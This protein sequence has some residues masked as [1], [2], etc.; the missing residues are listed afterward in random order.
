[1]PASAAP[2]HRSLSLLCAVSAAWAFSFGLGA[3]LASLWLADH[4][5]GPTVIGLNTAAYYAGIAAA[6]APLPWLMTRSARACVVAGLVLAALTTAFFPAVDGL[7][8]W[9]LIRAVNGLS[10]ALFLIPIETLVNRGA[11]PRRR[12]RD[13]GLYASSIALGIGLG[14]VVGLPVY[15]QAPRLAFVLGGLLPLLVTAPAWALPAGGLAGES[16]GWDA[17]V[18]LRGNLFGFGT[19]WAQGFLEGGMVTFL[20]VYLRSLGMDQDVAGGL[21]GVLFLGVLAFQ[22][23]VA[24]LADCGERVRVVLG[25]HAAVF[26]G[27]LLLPFCAGVA[28]IGAL[29]FVVGGCCAALYPM[30]LALLGERLPPEAL[31]R[32]NSR[33]LAWNCVGSLTGPVVMGLAL[34]FGGPYALF[35]SGAASVALAL[36][37]RM[38]ERRLAPAMAAHESERRAA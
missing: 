11:P 9:F 14:S 19:A 3:P 13:F 18:R 24:W 21:T 7:A 17:P 36:A 6:A 35:A 32:A 30:G 20:S 34:T 27:M 33:Y 12:A 29:L 23:P 2:V 31:G 8:W 16:A 15:P 26:A 5:C 25:C 38:L 28:T 10:S 22:L 1:M 37:A 4:G